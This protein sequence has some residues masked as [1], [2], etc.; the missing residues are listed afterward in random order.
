MVG[1]NTQGRRSRKTSPEAW[2]CL[3]FT[4]LA[5]NSLDSKSALPSASAVIDNQRV[6]QCNQLA[7]QSGI[8]PNMGVNHALMLNPEIA[9]LERDQ[10]REAQKLQE[11]AYWAYHFTSLV[12]LYNFFCDK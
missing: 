8:H 4:R 10:P 3:R 6:W 9:L 2:L 12:S 7:A 1:E 11:L 5:L